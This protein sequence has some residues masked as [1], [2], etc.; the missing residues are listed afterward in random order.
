MDSCTR[1]LWRSDV[2]VGHGASLLIIRNA[3]QQTFID[4]RFKS[5]TR[6]W[7]A[8][9]PDPEVRAVAHT[10]SPP[11][12]CFTHR[13]G[14]AQA[15][16]EPTSRRWKW[17]NGEQLVFARWHENY[18]TGEPD[19]IYQKYTLALHSISRRGLQWRPFVHKWPQLPRAQER[20]EYHPS[21]FEGW[22]VVVN[23]YWLSAQL[24]VHQRERNLRYAFYKN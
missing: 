8:L 2:C 24:R 7:L 18:W 16:P 15:S 9:L 13:I 21:L 23:D 11:P 17:Q 1:I 4:Y 14:C 19:N 10:Q 12:L 6:Y 5:G 22:R 20:D 3:D